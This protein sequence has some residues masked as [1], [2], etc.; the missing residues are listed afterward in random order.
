MI[1]ARVC[2]SDFVVSSAAAGSKLVHPLQQV[3][4]AIC[5]T[6]GNDIVVCIAAGPIG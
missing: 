4:Q 2:D 1:S 6:L 3:R 5:T